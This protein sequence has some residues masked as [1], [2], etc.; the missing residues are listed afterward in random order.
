MIFLKRLEAYG[1]KSFAQPTK[2]IFE[3]GLI[4]VV[5]PNGAGKS[6]ISDAIRW[7]L[8]EQSN[9]SLRAGSSGD[10]IFHGSEDLPSLNFA[11]VKLIF[12]NKS[13]IFD[14]DYNEVEIMRRV[15]RDDR[16]NEY[17]INKER[18]RLKDIHRLVMGT[19]LVKG[20]LAIISQGNV[21][22]LAQAKPEERRL[23]FEE[24][25]NA[26]K[27]KTQKNESLR[28]LDKTTANLQRID[29]IINEISKNIYF[30]E[31]QAKKAEKYLKE[32]KQ[33]K[34]LEVQ[35]L[36]YDI[37]NAYQKLKLST[38]EDEKKSKLVNDYYYDLKNYEIKIE[39]LNNNITDL[40]TK[41]S[42]ANEKI[43][44]LSTN[45]TDLE[46]QQKITNNYNLE[47]KS[48]NSE[49]QLKINISKL[50]LE[51]EQQQNLIN[52]EKQQL[53]QLKLTRENLISKQHQYI[54]YSNNLNQNLT[55]LISKKQFLLEK[56]EDHLY[57][58]V[59]TI[60]N[61]KNHLSGIIGTVGQIIKV[62]AEYELAMQEAL[63]NTIQNVL[64]N[65]YHDA[66]KA[67][68]FLK[69]NQAGVA[70]FLPLDSIKTKEINHY[71]LQIIKSQNGFIGLGSDLV[72]FDI[73]YSPII[74]YLLGRI[75]IFKN[76]DNAYEL[77]K[78]T[79]YRYYIIT[80]QGDV[81]RPGGAVAGGYKKL[82]ERFNNDTEVINQ[83][84][85]D[86][87]ALEVNKKKHQYLWQEIA[88]ELA[89]I[90]NN[91]EQK[92]LNLG[93]LY[94][95]FQNIKSKLTMY[96]NEYQKKY[97]SI[98]EENELDKQHF[99]IQKEIN[100]YQ[101]Q[102][103]LVTNELISNQNDRKVFATQLENNNNKLKVIRHQYQL[104]NQEVQDIQ[105]KKIKLESFLEHNL[106]YLNDEYKMT[107]E[108]GLS[109]YGGEEIVDEQNN[110]KLISELKRSLQEI[111]PVNLEVIEQ[112]KETNERYEFLQSQRKEI[113][114]A[115][116][117]LL[118][119][120]DS[121]DK[122]MIK[123]FDETIKEINAV[124]PET[125]SVL[126]GG[127]KAQLVYT[128]PD[129]LLTT[130]IDI[131]VSPPGKTVI[132]LNLLSGGEKSLVALSVLFAILKVRPLPLVVMDEVEAPLD[133]SNVE[134]FAK[135]VRTFIDKTQFIIVTH[136]PGTM[137]NC[138]LLYGVTMQKRGVSNIVA[139]NLVEA[140]KIN[141]SEQLEN[142]V[143][144][145]SI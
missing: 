25:A 133:P 87:N 97:S 9:K 112:F 10:I 11:E 85:E 96:Q 102:K 110:R 49:E 135:Y 24:A 19:G 107:Y 51:Y 81:I 130:G 117:K 64:V 34:Q 73:L 109:K 82:K 40:D 139:M 116:E 115:Q 33:L 7:V 111:G 76:L 42:N 100:K 134:R 2:I 47:N 140:K 39:K 55:Q 131:N 95:N 124:L 28:N 37:N 12:N 3:Q 4:G 41:I 136:R 62:P 72:E 122:I 21:S 142:N 141:L 36:I 27:Y 108:Y 58:G 98:L 89:L 106:N 8:G 60:L 54:S 16:E 105:L 63:N 17:F 69:N 126:F 99:E 137:E 138:D 143:I 83:I 104:L 129:D 92:Q 52:I 50:K 65:T 103:I 132:N 31:K 20:S 77:T 88:D 43:N 128:N 46:Y 71:D 90:N 123:R 5:G 113:V 84:T 23:L 56:K 79:N 45:I 29:D 101:S 6:N 15:Y 78:L 32:K 75:I 1:F 127:G 121:M 38:D 80:L 35:F 74:K 94:E 125:F 86:I 30:L 26:L 13:R 57:R 18:V 67:V 119:A 44:E 53:E 91:L 144:K 68:E 114:Q 14:L 120:I 59:K 145:N 48:E 61:H 118:S 93:R 66:K 70:T 22:H